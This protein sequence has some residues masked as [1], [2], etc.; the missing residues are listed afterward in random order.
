MTW[1]ASRL[2]DLVEAKPGFACGDDVEHGVFQFRMNN[3]TTE[4]ALDLARRRRVPSNSR[5][6]HDFLLQPGDV[7]FNATN[8]PELVGKSAFFSGLDEPATFSNHFLRLRSMGP[9]DGRYLARWLTWQQQRTTFMGLCRQWVNQ[10]SVSREALLSLTIPL[11]P[12]PEQRRIAAILD[13]A[14]ELRAKRR[15]AL[16]GLDNLTKSIFLD[17]CGD[18]F[19]PETDTQHLD[20]VAEVHMGQ[21]P[22]GATY[23]NTGAG[24]A[25][26]NGPSEFGRRHPVA[27]QWTTAP[28]RRC[29]NGD[30]LVCVRGATAGRLNI[31][32]DEYCLG[33]GVAAIRPRLESGLN[34]EYL[35]AVL[36]RYYHYFQAKGVG[37][38]FI[39]INRTELEQLP[40]PK[41]ERRVAALFAQRIAEVEHLTG[42]HRA[43]RVEMDTLF[44]SIQHRAFRNEL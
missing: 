17:M 8:S 39:N 10:A 29:T 23:N 24:L 28:T 27:V 42:V 16:A 3:V 37:S 12:I 15:V 44:A 30:V 18:P 6:L 43:S 2:V 33:R 4:G 7:L 26:L 1:T 20:E 22:P 11:P 35:Y 9:I 31:A 21:S 14:D 5:K 19:A 25:L 36:S 41:V 38:T 13:Q 34:T 32:D 40:I